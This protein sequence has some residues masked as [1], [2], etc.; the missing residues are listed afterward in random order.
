MWLIGALCIIVV[1]GELGSCFRSLNIVDDRNFLEEA[2]LSEMENCSP[3]QSTGVGISNNDMYKPEKLDTAN[4]L[5][6]E[7]R[8]HRRDLK[9]SSDVTRYLPN[10][11]P[12]YRIQIS[13]TCIDCSLENIHLSC[14]EWASQTLVNP[15][16][17]RRV[18]ENDCVVNN[19]DALV[20]QDIVYFEYSNSF[21]YPMN[22]RSANPVC[23]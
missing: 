10:G 8:C 21:P 11:M 22:V 13:N 4:K 2:K 20:S 6:A 1:G 14:G 23:K 9:V 18:R 17:F 19:G 16:L 12:I 5:L 7:T 3:T 15:N